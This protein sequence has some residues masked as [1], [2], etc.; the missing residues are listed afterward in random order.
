MIIEI[1]RKEFVVPECITRG[2]Y[3]DN[4]DG[5]TPWCDRGSCENWN[6]CLNGG[7]AG[8]CGPLEVGRRP[9]VMD[10]GVSGNR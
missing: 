1:G 6:R 7:R 10:G 4:V 8:G 2:T 9:G 3:L 5:L